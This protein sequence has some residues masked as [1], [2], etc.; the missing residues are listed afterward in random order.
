MK[1]G[2][3]DYGSAAAPSQYRC[4]ICR[5]HGV[6]LWREYNTLA[7]ETRLLCCDCAGRD[8]RKDVRALDQFGRRETKHGRT[9]QI[10][11]LF[12]AVPTEDGE[13]FWGHT[14]VPKSG[15]TWW[16]G[17]PNRVANITVASEES[18]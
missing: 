3:V 9:D 17:L 15:V 8:Q 14:S 7:D 1:M 18:R 10:G 11:G 13:T 2:K 16:C 12:L 5:A 6:K 4:S